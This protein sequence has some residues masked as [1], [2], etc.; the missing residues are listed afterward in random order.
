MRRLNFITFL[1]ALLIVCSLHASAQERGN[2]N[3]GNKREKFDKEAF[4]SKRNAYIKEKVA[5]SSEEAAAFLPLENEL[6]LK[7]F[8]IGRQCKKLERELRR[9][10]SKSDEEYQKLL[11]CREEVEEKRDKL[12]KEYQKKFKKIL[13][14]GQLLEYQNVDRA[15]MDEF[16]RNRKKP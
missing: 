12:D 1:T 2:K 13:S 11:K 10:K 7:K 3:R 4:L 9:K 14:A 6:M 15:F 5:L 8:E 16:M